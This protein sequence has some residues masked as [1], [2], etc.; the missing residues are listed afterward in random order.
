M[1]KFLRILG[2]VLMVIGF[3]FVLGAADAVTGTPHA[4]VIILGMVGFVFMYIGYKIYIMFGGES[5]FDGALIE[6]IEA[7]KKG[8]QR[9]TWYKL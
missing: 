9:W 5:L 7:E 1:D 8:T 6:V 4:S 2:I 3:G